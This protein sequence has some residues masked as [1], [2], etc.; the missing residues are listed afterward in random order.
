MSEAT[1]TQTEFEALLTPVLPAA[2]RAALHFT[3]SP[4]DAEDAVQQASLQAWRAFK[5]FEGGTNFRA[6]FLCIV[7]NVCRSEFRRQSRTPVALAFDDPG[8][9][10]L[11]LS[12][13]LTDETEL[14]PEGEAIRQ[15]DAAEIQAA[16]LSLPEE[17]RTVA[18]LYFV[19]DLSYQEIAA[20][21]GRPI[22]TV[23]S[24]LH[25]GRKMLMRQLWALA[26][27]RGIVA[28][29]REEAEDFSEFFAEETYRA[30]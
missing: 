28:A 9:E 24:R 29:Q 4:A 21:V 11:P 25:R 30:A 3:R 20:V 27:E 23:R 14:T 12:D 6:W 22:G 19:D 8:E 17:Y 1:A 7:T 13:V 26:E 15:L 16:L 5:T 2:Y 18:T 10:G